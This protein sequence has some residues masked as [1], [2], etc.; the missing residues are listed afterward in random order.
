M[1]IGGYI[2]ERNFYNRESYVLLDATE[3]EITI[4]KLGTCGG[5]TVGYWRPLIYYRE[6]ER[7]VL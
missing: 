2:F 4:F 5:V 3:D 7:Y 1:F 6:T